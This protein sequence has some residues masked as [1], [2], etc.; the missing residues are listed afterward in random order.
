MSSVG[1][2]Q[3]ASVVGVLMA[4][5]GGMAAC[6]DPPAAPTRFA[7][8]SQTDLRVGSGTAVVTGNIIRVHYTGWF[9]EETAPEQKGAVFESSRTGSPIQLAVG[10]SGVIFGWNQGLPGMQ[11]GGLRRL[12]IPP[13]LGYGGFRTGPVPPWTTMVFEIELVAIDQ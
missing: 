10:S 4:A 3:R 8:Y 7:P 11:V 2:F 13:S 6:V 1:V 12:V 5:L 9:F